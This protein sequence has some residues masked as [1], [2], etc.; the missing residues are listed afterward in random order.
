MLSLSINLGRFIHFFIF[1]GIQLNW[2][3]YI[4][5]ELQLHLGLLTEY[6]FEKVEQLPKSDIVFDHKIYDKA[7]SK[8]LAL[9]KK[10]IV[11]SSNFQLNLSSQFRSKW[12]AAVQPWMNN[13]T[14]I[15]RR[16]SAQIR[17]VKRNSR[18]QKEQTK[19]SSPET[20]K[21][22]Q[23]VAEEDVEDSQQLMQHQ[24]DITTAL[25]IATQKKSTIDVAMD[26]VRAVTPKRRGNNVSMSLDREALLNAIDPWK[27][28]EIDVDLNL[29]IPLVQRV[30]EQCHLLLMDSYSRFKL[31]R[32]R[33]VEYDMTDDRLVKESPIPS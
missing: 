9:Y 29:F 3:E 30:L 26:F 11:V 16:L 5:S 8:I 18:I 25:E 7:S 24:G 32:D 6:R 31:E 14:S 4:N 22:L 10:Y 19:E 17:K 20:P 28:V 21:E 2:N 15:G 1:I 27:D 12:T 23:F 33:K 13:A